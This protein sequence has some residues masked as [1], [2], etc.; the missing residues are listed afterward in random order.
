MDIFSMF[1][2]VISMNIDTIFI[3]LSFS[4]KLTKLSKINMLLIATITTLGTYLALILGKSFNSVL[5][6]N[7][8]NIIGS[9]ALLIIGI[10]MIKDHF[11]DTSLDYKSNNIKDIIILSLVLSINNFGFGISSSMI[12]INIYLMSIVNFIITYLF[13]ILSLKWGTKLLATMFS[14]YA[15]LLAGLIIIIIA[16]L[17]LII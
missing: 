3:G 13:L 15:N 6:L 16:I 4:S 7:T 2:I 10:W 12:G 14:N 5:D 17:N 9:I 8:I 1:W 11:N